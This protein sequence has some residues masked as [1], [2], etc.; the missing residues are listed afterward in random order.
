M[1]MDLSL[2]YCLSLIP[3]P[4]MKLSLVPLRVVYPA[5]LFTGNYNEDVDDFLPEEDDFLAI[6]DTFS[7][8]EEGTYIINELQDDDDAIIDGNLSQPKNSFHSINYEASMIKQ[9][10]GMEV[11]VASHVKQVS[12]SSSAK[13]RKEYREDDSAPSGLTT[14]KT[15]IYNEISR[16]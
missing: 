14:R 11:E 15:S 4:I 1:L 12:S 13:R 6:D 16:C 3:L 9:I 10:K 8:V 7:G 2:G 5:D